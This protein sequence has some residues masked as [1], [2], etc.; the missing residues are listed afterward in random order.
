MTRSKLSI[1]KLR[2][3]RTQTLTS[4]VLL[5]LFSLLCY[6]PVFAN[7]GPSIAYLLGYLKIGELLLGNIT[8]GLFESFFIKK[9]LTINNRWWVIIIANYVSA[10]GGFFVTQFL[11]DHTL[12]ELQTERIGLNNMNNLLLC[13]LVTFILTLLLEGPI[14]W[15]AIKNKLD[16]KYFIK[17]LLLPNIVSYTIIAIL[18]TLLN[19]L[20]SWS[21]G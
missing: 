6:Y 7:G 11:L 18:Y 13:Y 19:V 20:S 21:G 16:K 10:F 17:M 12:V 1:K 4:F 5:F 14:Y 3:I 15:F 2:L 9:A 8:I